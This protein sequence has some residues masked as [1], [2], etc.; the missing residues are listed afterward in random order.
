[1]ATLAEVRVTLAAYETERDA[2]VSARVQEM[3]IGQRRVYFHD[4]A[5]IEKMID[6][7]ASLETALARTKS[8]GFRATRFVR[9]SL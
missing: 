4:L 2:L 3:D 1:M 9:N 6:K 5:M 7:Y 8:A